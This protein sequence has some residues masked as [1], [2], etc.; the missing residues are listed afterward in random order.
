MRIGEIV[1]TCSMHFVGE[2]Y[3]LHRPPAL[4]RLVKVEVGPGSR[5]YAVVSYGQT[6]GLE[7][8]RRAIRRGTDEVYDEAIYREHPELR[9]TLR[10]VFQALLVGWEDGPR[11]RQQ[12]PPQPPPLHFSVRECDPAEVTRFSDG[13]YYL[14]LLLSATTD[15]P[16]L[17]LIVAHITETY[18]L[19]GDDRDWLERAAREL[20]VLLKHDHE[21]LMGI[22]YAIEP[23]P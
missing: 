10:T 6:S 18:R 20:A 3:D 11:L 17:H 21:A 9:R 5:I 12:L 2:G 4:G 14:R 7:P 15:T 23:G 16:A 8:G 22:L 1:E 13:L 19:R